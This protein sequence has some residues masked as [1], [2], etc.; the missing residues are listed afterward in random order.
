MLLALSMSAVTPASAFVSYSPPA[1]QRARFGGGGCL[2]GIEHGGG[3]LDFRNFLQFKN[4]VGRKCFAMDASWRGEAGLLLQIVLTGVSNPKFT[5]AI[6]PSF[7]L[8]DGPNV[9]GLSEGA[10]FAPPV[11][12]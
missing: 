3:L 8:T 4:Q 6:L 11:V 10:R 7:P 9:P 1:V 2:C 12:M 5:S